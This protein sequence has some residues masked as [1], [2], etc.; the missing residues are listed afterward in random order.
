MDGVIATSVVSD[1]RKGH[2]VETFQLLQDAFVLLCLP[3]FLEGGSRSSSG[4]S[5]GLLLVTDCCIITDNMLS[6]HA[7]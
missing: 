6:N 2:T 7:Y 4:Y 5:A 3:V 1:E